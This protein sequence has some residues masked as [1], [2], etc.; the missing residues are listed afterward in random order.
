MDSNGQMRSNM[1]QSCV[2][3]STAGLQFCIM[4]G[5]VVVVDGNGLLWHFFFDKGIMVAYGAAPARQHRFI[6]VRHISSF[7]S[8]VSWLKCTGV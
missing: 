5:V 4:A 8:F 1:P 2:S 7:S 6:F 3:G